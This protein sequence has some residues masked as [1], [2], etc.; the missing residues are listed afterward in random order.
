MKALRYHGPGRHS[1]EDVPAPSLVDQTDAVVRLERANQ[2]AEIG[3]V[4][5]C[6]TGAQRGAVT[7]LD[8]MGNFLDEFVTN[9][10]VFIAHRHVVEYRI[11][12][13][14]GTVHMF[15][16]GAPRRLTGWNEW[17]GPMVQAIPTRQL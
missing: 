6:D 3:L 14:W 2:I 5:I 16:H 7:R 4:Q 11:R 17:S 15:V 10:T 13:G 8:R 9:F 1:W 12:S